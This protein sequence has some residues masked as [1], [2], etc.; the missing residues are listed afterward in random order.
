MVLI[1]LILGVE[2]G[3][4]LF[5]FTFFLPC[6]I[7][8]TTRLLL[9]QRQFS[10]LHLSWLKNTFSGQKGAPF[11]SCLVWIP[12]TQGSSQYKWASGARVQ[13][14][15]C[16]SAHCRVDSSWSYFNGWN[17]L[18]AEPVFTPNREA[19]FKILPFHYCCSFIPADFCPVV[20]FLLMKQFLSLKELTGS[21]NRTHNHFIIVQ[22]C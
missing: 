19:I 7:Q 4:L 5:L 13:S 16:Q 9:F 21:Q 11:F 14:I 15:P 1:T 18:F 20:Q 3:T 12:V 22:L 6:N 2:P 8:Q 10:F 17:R